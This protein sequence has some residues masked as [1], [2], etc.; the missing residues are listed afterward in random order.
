MLFIGYAI[1]N[2]RFGFHLI[3]LRE[4]QDAAESLGVKTSRSKLIALLISAFFTSITGTFYAQYIL[5]IDPSTL[6]SLGFSVELALF[7]IIG[8]LGT[9]TG[10]ILGAFL[11][12]PLDV[13]LR[14]WLGGVSAGLNFIVYGLVLMV[15]VKY[16][17][18][19]IFGWVENRVKKWKRSSQERIPD[20]AGRPAVSA[21]VLPRTDRQAPETGRS[22][23][24]EARSLNK[25]F[26]GLQ[27]VKDLSFSIGC[28]E[29]LG[30]I[31]PNGAG[32]TTVFNLVSGFMRPESGSIFLNGQDLT[33]LRPPHR[34]CIKG[35]GR[36]F[37]IVK[38]FQNMTVLENIMVGV[39]SHVA[40]TSQARL[41]AMEILEFIGLGRYSASPSSSLTIADRKRLELGRA[42]A[43]KPDLLLL[44]EVVAG[45]NPRETQDLI[46]I[47]RAV[48]AKGVTILMIEHVM[49]AV[50]NLSDRIIV[51]HH[52]EKIAEGDPGEIAQNTK[53]IDA[54]LGK[55]YRQGGPSC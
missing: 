12:T 11:L 41:E 13:F 49:K 36:T 28:N 6:F 9:V 23:L 10:P 29:V 44:D 45:L 21:P 48:S 4:D 42:L 47:I 32:K 34:A 51:I 54:Y 5:F 8:G 15:A 55:K 20:S 24:F 27:A 40:N 31:G 33:G 43:T 7:A 50:M 38:P 37:Q 16:F 35:I 2:S 17:P 19:G 1:R 25:R 26:G 52:G 30:L 3:S 22:L 14:A 46:D 18:L 53:V 39:F